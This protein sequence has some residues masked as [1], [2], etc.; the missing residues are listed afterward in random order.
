MI[1]THC[2]IDFPEYD[3]DRDQVIKR[4]KNTLDAVVLSGT[5]YEA[6]IGALKYAKEEKGFIY[7]SLGFH[8]V[9][10]QNATIEERKSVQKHII[11]NKKNISA[12][13]EVGMDYF[14]VKDKALRQKQKE[15]FLSFI[16]IANQEQIPL[17]MHVRDADKKALNIILDYED[18]PYVIFHCYSGS[19]KTARRIMEHENYFMSFSTMVCYSKQHQ[20]LASQIPID[21][22][23]TETDSPYLAMTKEER[24]EPSNVKLAVKKI[25]ELQNIDIENVDKVTTN[26]AKKVFKIK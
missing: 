26:N 9:T 4:A 12:I 14:F 7:P 5:N 1:D 11:E 22:M 6:N 17:L 15:I 18:I 24:N 25:A 21:Y 16:E 13:G 2:H 10:S 8:P 20:D 23:L 3:K 19:L